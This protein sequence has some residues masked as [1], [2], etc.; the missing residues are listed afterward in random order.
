MTK[1][2]LRKYQAALETKLRELEPVKQQ[3][4]NIQISTQSEPNDGATAMTVYMA[5]SSADLNSSI[6]KAVMAALQ[7]IKNGNYGIC[8]GCEKEIKKRRLDAVPWT[9]LCIDCQEKAEKGD[10]ELVIMIRMP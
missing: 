10:P 2:E 4:A 6:M 3:V 1:Q 9:P 7:R 5:I 8:L